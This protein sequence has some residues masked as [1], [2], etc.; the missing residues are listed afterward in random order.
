MALSPGFVN[1]VTLVRRGV[2]A[3][4]DGVKLPTAMAMGLWKTGTGAQ[5]P[6]DG[7]L[8]GGDADGAMEAAMAKQALRVVYLTLGVLEDISLATGKSVPKPNIPGT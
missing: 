3:R 2:A 7:A 6:L 8:S 4:G 1:E 5:G